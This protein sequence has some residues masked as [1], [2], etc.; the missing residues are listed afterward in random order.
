M[1]IVVDLVARF[2]ALYGEEPRVFRAP[3]RVNLIG[4][5]TDY[6]DGFVLPAAIDLATFAAIARRDDRRIVVHSL[7]FA[8]SVEFDLD[9]PAPTP[10]G[11]WSDYV[12]GVAVALEQ[13]GHRLTGANLMLHGD[14]PMGSGLSASAALEVATGFALCALSGV[15][16]DPTA[17]A[18]VCE[19]AENDFVGMRCGVMDQFISCR[20]VDDHAVLLD[21]RSLE[22]RPVH[23][24]SDARLVICNTMAHHALATSAYNTRREQCEQAVAILSRLIANVTALRDVTPDQLQKNSAHLPEPLLRRARHVVSE[25]ARTLRAATALETG[26]LAEC[27]RLM[28]ESHRSLRDDYEVSC[29]EADLMVDLAHRIDGVFGARMTGGGFGG[30]TVNLVERKAVARLT[31]S[32]GEGYRAATGVTPQIFVCRP[33]RGVDEEIL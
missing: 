13:S 25:N 11:D 18:L 24:S 30:C 14:L 3:G 15:A 31:E 9:D 33:A 1:T 21:C 10:R 12:R 28:N 5:H 7:A 4:E 6:N 20:G 19:R 22:M 26:D 8:Q 23:I 29:S 27:G 2:G 17:L 16:L 32:V